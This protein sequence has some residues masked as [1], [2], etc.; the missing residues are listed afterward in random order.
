MAIVQQEPILFSG[1]IRENIIYGLNFIPTDD[2]L[3]EACKQANALAFVKD[4]SLFPQGYDTLVGERGVKL[5]G[6]QKQRVAIARALIR[7]PKILLL[8]E[9]TSALDAESEHQV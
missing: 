5:S 1:T 3:D 7:K 4:T 6:G 2:Q 9:A 8:D